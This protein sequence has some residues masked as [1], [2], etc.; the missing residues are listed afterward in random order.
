ME[1]SQLSGEIRQ[2]DEFQCRSRSEPFDVCL[3]AVL[4]GRL[5][6][7]LALDQEAAI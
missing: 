2:K 4:L 1:Q 6:G 5:E 7:S 3:E